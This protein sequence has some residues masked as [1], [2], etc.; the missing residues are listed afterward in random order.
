MSRLI[1]R[2]TFAPARSYSLRDV[3]EEADALLAAARAEAD[4]ILAEARVRGAELL[5]RLRSEGRREGFEQGRREAL[6]ALD[7]QARADAA[8]RAQA[9]V[10]A[11]CEALT[12]SLAAFDA[13]KRRLIAAAET[14]IIALALAIA[15]RV[16]KALPDLSID[17]AAANARHALGLARHEHDVRL[18]LH[19][20]DCAA[21]R[22][23][24][25]RFCAEIDGLE[26]VTLVPDESLVRGGCVVRGAHGTIDASIDVQLDRV[27]EALL[28]RG[29]Q[30]EPPPNVP[31]ARGETP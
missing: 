9:Q 7:A 23:M 12:A 13:R 25:E 10:D 20:A 28:P 24:A 4:G 29:S 18:H 11:L 8:R 16:C 31:A 17:A 22:G 2:E 30:T 19:P 1:R 3:R 27:A 5:E 14:G 6:E 21:L 15:R 26:H